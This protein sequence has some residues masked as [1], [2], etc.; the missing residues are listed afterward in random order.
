MVAIAFEP[1]IRHEG[2]QGA[3]VYPA[4]LSAVGIIPHAHVAVG[5]DG[6]L[7]SEPAAFQVFDKFLAA[8]GTDACIPYFPEHPLLV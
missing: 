3:C 1:G 5:K 6:L 7:A 4:V 2:I 8:L